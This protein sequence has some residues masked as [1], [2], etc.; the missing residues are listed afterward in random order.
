[1]K[2]TLAN[3][4]AAGTTD[5]VMVQSSLTQGN[6]KCYSYMNSGQTG[7][8]LRSSAYFRLVWCVTHPL[9]LQTGFSSFTLQFTSAVCLSASACLI[10]SSVSGRHG[11][12]PS[13]WVT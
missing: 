4:A 11:D 12:S 13:T 1:M 10:Y 2:W 5:S 3:E 6:R 9:C 8:H 7:R